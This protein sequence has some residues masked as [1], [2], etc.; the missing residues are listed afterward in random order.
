MNKFEKLKYIGTHKKDNNTGKK[1]AV[2]KAVKS[3]A[4][5]TDEQRAEDTGKDV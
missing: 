5:E 4:G 3:K 1:T 2:K